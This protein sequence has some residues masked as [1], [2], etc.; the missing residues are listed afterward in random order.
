[1]KKVTDYELFC[2]K[3]DIE[4]EDFSDSYIFVVYKVKKDEFDCVTINKKNKMAIS[5][6]KVYNKKEAKKWIETQ[7]Y[8]I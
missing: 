4:A 1:M 8:M 6:K 5:K 3:Y 2:Q 7:D